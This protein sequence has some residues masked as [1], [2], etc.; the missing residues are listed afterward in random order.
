MP[1]FRLSVVLI[2]VSFFFGCIH[3]YSDYDPEMDKGVTQ[4]RE[5]VSQVITKL[6]DCAVADTR[7]K[8]GTMPTD[9][10]RIICDRP[11]KTYDVRDYNKIEVQLDSLIV[12]SQSVPHNSVTT[13]DLVNMEQA[14]LQFPTASP[15]F[16]SS[17]K[18]DGD[19]NV[20]AAATATG[21]AATGKKQ[22]TRTS[23]QERHQDKTPIAL[24]TINE[25]SVGVN[26]QVRSI[27]TVEL[28]KKSGDKK[29]N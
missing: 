17:T 8:G 1:I 4:V 16:E 9:P 7:A 28:A 20:S 14:I 27:L 19:S 11:D 23:I 22:Q 26:Q 12:R 6:R 2:C 13:K 15:G 25:I 24:D 10:S 29:A 5:S 21:M 18:E 3:L